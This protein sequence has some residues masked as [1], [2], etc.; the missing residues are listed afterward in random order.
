MPPRQAARSFASIARDQESAR[1]PRSLV[2]GP[3]LPRAQHEAM[4]TAR[5]ASA[6]QDHHSAAFSAKRTAPS[7]T[8]EALTRMSPYGTYPMGEGIKILVSNS[9]HLTDQVRPSTFNGPLPLDRCPHGL[10]TGAGYMTS[11]WGRS[12]VE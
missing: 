2:V 9:M 7:V 12:N 3:R 10:S 6:T 4:G 11:R 1:H 8:P 5:S